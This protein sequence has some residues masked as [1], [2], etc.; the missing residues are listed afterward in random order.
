MPLD[1]VELVW[2]A[3]TINNAR[4]TQRT[5]GPFSWIVLPPSDAVE[6]R[7]D[8]DTPVL[9]WPGAETHDRAD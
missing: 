9:L 8:S 4:T 7:L 1:C 3:L 6:M 2:V 5:S